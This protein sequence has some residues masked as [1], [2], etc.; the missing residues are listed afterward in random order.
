[1]AW[2]MLL[3]L[4][5]EER[6]RDGLAPSMTHCPPV[7]LHLQAP[8]TATPGAA[9]GAGG[10]QAGGS[11]QGAG[12]TPFSQEREVRAWHLVLGMATVWWF[13][14]RGQR[15]GRRHHAQEREV[16]M[17]RLSARGNLFWFLSYF[18]CIFFVVFFLHKDVLQGV[19]GSGQGPCR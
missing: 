16:R 14:C 3:R 7:L 6:G 18:F 1:M 5:M 17:W 2:P 9:A 12:P 15:A 19:G 10:D 8:T 13:F 11:G 4:Q